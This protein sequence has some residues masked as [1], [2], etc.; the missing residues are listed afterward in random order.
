MPD[1]LK[2]LF[3]E[4][5]S[6]RDTIVDDIKSLITR[7][8][9]IDLNYICDGWAP[10]HYATYN[11]DGKLLKFLNEVGV[12][13]D[14]RTVDGEENNILHLALRKDDFDTMTIAEEERNLEA[15]KQENMFYR[16]LNHVISAIPLELWSQKDV[17][18]QTPFELLAKNKIFK[19][20]SSDYFLEA[21]QDDAFIDQVS[22][23]EENLFRDKTS[24]RRCLPTA[25]GSS[26]G[27]ENFFFIESAYLSD[28]RITSEICS[29]EILRRIDEDRK[30]EYQLIS[31]EEIERRAMLVED[32]AIEYKQLSKEE[33]TTLI[34]LGP[35]I[36]D[37]AG[38][39]K[40]KE[41]KAI[42]GGKYFTLNPRM[43]VAWGNIHAGGALGLQ[44]GF[45]KKLE[46][47][48]VNLCYELLTEYPEVVYALDSEGKNSLE[49]AAMLATKNRS[50]DIL[51]NPG[52]QICGILMSSGI[53]QTSSQCPT[54]H[55]D[56]RNDERR[57]ASVIANY[58]RLNDNE[59]LA[60]KLLVKTSSYGKLGLSKKMGEIYRQII[61]A[62][63]V[64]FDDRVLYRP[65]L[66]LCAISDGLEIHV[67]EE[68]RDVARLH[69]SAGAASPSGLTKGIAQ[70]IY[71]S[72][73]DDDLTECTLIHEMTHFACAQIWKNGMRPFSIGEEEKEFE[74]IVNK[75][76]GNL[77]DLKATGGVPHPTLQDVFET[78]SRE[79]W[80][81][82]LIARVPDILANPGEESGLKILKQQAPELLEF[83]KTKFIPRVNELIEANCR[84]FVMRK[85]GIQNIETGAEE[86]KAVG[87]SVAITDTSPLLDQSR[88]AH[89]LM[90]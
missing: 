59:H 34:A 8:A 76:R 33:R 73:A 38:S 79:K 49:H 6:N 64:M 69:T 45:L 52:I 66:H 16:E 55:D 12:K 62:E 30:V 86:S 15:I 89:S 85:L 26:I 42:K 19:L 70:E 3:E 60:A 20:F 83:Y 77:A 7:G 44:Y 53:D 57:A 47:G 46:E 40:F 58:Y 50:M 48:N 9:E 25:L 31:N 88:S 2:E 41:A 37:P 75:T 65:V 90:T 22:A 87:T 43:N 27:E 11:R 56:L 51:Q 23:L 10:I 17:S 68:K 24:L 72:A 13:L 54:F 28:A 78:Y 67:D 39:G 63:N 81:A 29:A 14:V 4:Y 80:A 35:L 36:K 82:E 32:R 84:E 71:L 74:E 21:D 5:P 18:D 1:H 61:N